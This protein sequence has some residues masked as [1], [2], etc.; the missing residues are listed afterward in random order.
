[1]NARSRG[2][3]EAAGKAEFAARVAAVDWTGVGDELDLQGNAVV[4]GNDLP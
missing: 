4:H 3:H 2:E 1:M